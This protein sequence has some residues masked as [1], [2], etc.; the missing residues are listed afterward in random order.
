ME[1][2]TNTPRRRIA[3]IV[4]ENVSQQETE[5]DQEKAFAEVPEKFN[6]ADPGSRFAKRVSNAIQQ[7]RF[8]Q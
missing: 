3:T 7:K 6:P 4:A 1:E 5:R 2:P 8:E